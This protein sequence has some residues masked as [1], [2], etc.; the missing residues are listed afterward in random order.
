ME[1]KILERR[2]LN[3]EIQQLILEKPWDFQA[4]QYT[5]IVFQDKLFYYSIAN[6]PFEAT[7]ELDIQ[8]SPIHPLDSEFAKFLRQAESLQLNSPAGEAFL[9]RND[10]PVILIAG[11]SGIAPMKSIAKTI[12][13]TREVHLYWGVRD[14]GCFFDLDS[15]NY[16]P[17]LSEE[18]VPNMRFGL[19]HE[20]VLADFNSLA[21]F[22]I[23]LAGPFAMSFAARDAFIKKG[24]RL[25]QLYSDAFAFG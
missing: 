22:D 12:A 11:G 24:A 2:T 3:C 18:H 17:V 4:G 13:G 9:R 1:V 6:S 19:V 20:A 15:L 10:S 8:N 14:R 7:L 25:D 23:Y 16:I 5:S 21:G